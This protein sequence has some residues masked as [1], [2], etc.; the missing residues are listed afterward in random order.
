MLRLN[1][2]HILVPH[3][4]P[5]EQIQ[6]ELAETQIGLVLG[7]PGSGKSAVLE[8]IAV[9]DWPCLGKLS[10]QGKSL[11]DLSPPARARL[12]I[13]CV[14]QSPR[15]ID[16][17]SVLEHVSLG[18]SRA[19]KSKPADIAE[20]WSVLPELRN[21]ENHLANQLDRPLQRL[22]ELGRVLIGDPKLILID[23]LT[24]DLGIPRMIELIGQLRA[25]GHSLLIADRLPAPLLPLA[26]IGIVLSG[27][28]MLMSGTAKE[29][30]ADPRVISICLGDYAEEDR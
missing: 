24:I 17:L 8:T 23:E 20:L 16:G 2:L 15:L 19:E 18:R 27:R 29:L 12:G 1:D 10:W 22:V 14:F 5:L 4:Q 7:A 11:V 21:F 25:R 9:G 30:Q 26:D 3:Q 6:L 28:Q 13:G